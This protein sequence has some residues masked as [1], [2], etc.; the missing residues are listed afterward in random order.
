MIIHEYQQGSPEW[1]AVR[2]GK[3][4]ASCFGKAVAGGQGKTRKAYMIQLLA[5]RLTQNDQNGYSNSTMDR[6]SEIEPFA[7]E[8]YERL[9]RVSVRQVGFVE[10]DE[11]I[12]ASPDGLVGEDG[13]IEIKCPFSTTHIEYL[14]AERLPPVYRKQVQGQ[15]WVCERQWCDFVSYDPR[16]R[17][18]PFFCERVYRDE[19]YIKELHIKII[20]FIDEMKK[21]MS[22]LTESPF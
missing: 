12:G 5:E 13:M 10:R 22:E 7:R 11:N 15:L 19:A 1:F 20:M 16:V 4:T 17:Q 2:L 6:G 3:V 14:L 18:R 21:L 9:N 8:Y